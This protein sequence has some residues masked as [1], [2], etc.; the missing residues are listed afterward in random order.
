MESDTNR[1]LASADIDWFIGERKWRGAMCTADERG[2]SQRVATNW[3]EG[4][5]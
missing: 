1:R 5:F 4:A 3:G 2:A